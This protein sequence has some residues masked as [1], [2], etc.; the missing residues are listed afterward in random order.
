VIF[1]FVLNLIYLYVRWCA[2]QEF[3]TGV[4]RANYIAL[5]GWGGG[6]IAQP[7]SE[8]DIKRTLDAYG[9]SAYA[10]GHS[11]SYHT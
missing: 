1:G 2:I 8:I 5:G 11:F 6:T 7:Y 10:K 4:K 9:R 3:S